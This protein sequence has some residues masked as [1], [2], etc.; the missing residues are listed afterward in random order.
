M[1]EESPF[2][3]VPPLVV[4]LTI[5]AALV[6]AILALGA[7]GLVGG[8]AAVGW[9]SQA[10]ADWG[11][12]PLVFE[13]VAYR[14]DW[15]FDLVR[16]FVTYAFIQGGVT[17]ALFGIALLLALGKFVGEIFH[18]V[19]LAILL[20]LCTV[21]GAVAFCAIFS[22]PIALIGLFPAVYGLIGAFTYLL[23]LKLGGLGQNR[24]TAFRLIGVLM[25]FQL[26]FSLLFG[27]SPVWVAEVAGFVTGF[28]SSVLL[29]PGGWSGFVE[30]MRARG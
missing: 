20:L 7:E 1:Q 23:W 2:G 30:R 17:P 28:A 15:S 22:G 26:A 11:V 25:A 29:A 8:P 24:L 9:R 3:A 16:R 4:A 19:A 27:A 21:M 14:G 5:V 12:S 6:E 18:P 13:Q 10:V